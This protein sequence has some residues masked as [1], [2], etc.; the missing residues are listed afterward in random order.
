MRVSGIW[1]SIFTL[2]HLREVL[3]GLLSGSTRNYYNRGLLAL[4]LYTLGNGI[5]GQTSALL[6]DCNPLAKDLGGWV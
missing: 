6:L 1:L 3:A 5:G 4:R 2:T